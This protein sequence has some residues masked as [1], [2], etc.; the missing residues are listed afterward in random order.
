M[1]WLVDEE[2]ADAARSLLESGDV[3][4]APR[5]MAS[6]VASSIWRKVGANEIEHGEA[7]DLQA[8]I[9]TWPVKWHA[10]ETVSAE[11][12]HLALVLDHPTY[13]CVY[14]ALAHQIR[15]LVITADHRFAKTLASSEYNGPVVTLAEYSQ[16]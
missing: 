8:S 10:D 6:E 4:H 16:M 11:A 3:L 7:L 1:K 13:D 15:A 5:L 9:T 12:L 2:N 14:L